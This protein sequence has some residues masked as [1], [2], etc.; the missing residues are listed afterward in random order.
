MRQKKLII[1]IIKVIFVLFLTIFAADRTFADEERHTLDFFYFNVC[2][3]CHEESNIFELYDR[4]ITDLEKETISC[5]IRTYNT[6]QD[7]AM[8][9]YEQRLADAGK[10]KADI[11][12]PVLIVDGVWLSGYET[13]EAELQ[14]LLLGKKVSAEKAGI[15]E[16][17]ERPEDYGQQEILTDR[18]EKSSGVSRPVITAADDTPAILL[19]TTYL[20]ADCDRA[21][22]EIEELQGELNF[23]VIEYS[24]AEDGNVEIFK[25]LLAQYGRTQEEGKVP[26]VFAGEYALIG[27][28]E[29]SQGLR[30][31]L[32]KGGATASVLRERLET[33]ASDEAWGSK[34]ASAFGA[35]FLA[36]WNPCMISMTLMLLSILLTAH[37]SVLK[38]GLLWLAAK[39]VTYLGIGCVACFAA[40]RFNQSLFTKYGS[41]LNIVLA[42]LFFAT[43][44]MN[45]I[46]FLNVRKEEYGKIRMQLPKRL[47]RFNHTLLKRA[48]QAEGATLI[49]LVLGLGVAVSL[50]EF[51]CTGQIYM[52]SILYLLRSQGGEQTRNFAYLLLY[53]TAMSIPG[54]ATILVIHFTKMIGRV[55]DFM[56]RHLGTIKLVNTALFAL[57]ALYFLFR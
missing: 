57:Y 22:E 50:G 24:I 48:G 11:E 13:M 2:A 16:Q 27:E 28:E 23:N 32:E 12:L 9:V 54:A 31:V 39:Y 45:Y 5:E 56:L 20:C 14:G 55:S 36:G 15:S 33:S 44:V 53:V 47:R 38:N 6:F 49:F 25:T 37:A 41:I 42:A 26:A 8:T 43:A 35:G 52:A 51:F 19:F 7:A 18:S 30:S 34:L 29:I 40:S 3:S 4:C 17:D 1:L 21:K 46:D 10:E